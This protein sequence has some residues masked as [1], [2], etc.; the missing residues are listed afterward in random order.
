MVEGHCRD[1]IGFQVMV[2][3]AV[4]TNRILNQPPIYAGLVPEN[5]FA[6]RGNADIFLVC[7]F[8]T[9]QAQ[10]NLFNDVSCSLLAV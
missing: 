1:V 2:R 8:L 4:W 9:N 10:K 5:N 6:T 7:R 3:S